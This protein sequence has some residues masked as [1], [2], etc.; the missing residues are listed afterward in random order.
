MN[1]I[2]TGL[3]GSGKTKLG[4]ILSRKLNWKFVDTDKEIEEAVGKKISVI[5]EL[6]GWE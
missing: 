5:V 6:R 2:L 4:K 3:R 1:I